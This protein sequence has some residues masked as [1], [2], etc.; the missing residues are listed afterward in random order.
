MVDVLNPF[1]SEDFDIME[2]KIKLADETIEGINKAKMAGIDTGTQLEDI[3]K[4][5][6][7]IQSILNTYKR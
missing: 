6:E 3:R 5:K 4:S 2:E 1:S 7:K